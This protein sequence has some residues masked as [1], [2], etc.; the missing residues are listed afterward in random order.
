MLAAAEVNASIGD[1]GVGVAI[2][3]ER[4]RQYTE[5][6]NPHQSKYFR[7]KPAALG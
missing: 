4:L 2:G 5:A 1:C 6:E 3:P 7:Y